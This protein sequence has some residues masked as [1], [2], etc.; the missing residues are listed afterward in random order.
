MTHT[1]KEAIVSGGPLLSDPTD[2][3]WL[4]ST[5]LKGVSTKPFKSFVLIGNSD[6]PEAIYLYDFEDPLITDEAHV[7]SFVQ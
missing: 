7:V 1:N 5:H 3:A 4:M 6:C 2:I